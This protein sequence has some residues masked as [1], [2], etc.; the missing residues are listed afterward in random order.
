MRDAQRNVTAKVYV[1]FHDESLFAVV[2]DVQR[3]CG[4]WTNRGKSP[5]LFAVVRD[6]K[7]NLPRLQTVTKPISVSI[8]VVRDVQRNVFIGGSTEDDESF[9]SL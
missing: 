9:Y 3:N 1:M 4:G 5:F 2:R 8:R 6:A 7:R